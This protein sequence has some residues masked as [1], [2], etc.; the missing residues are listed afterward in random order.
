MV[1]H[2]LYV[3]RFTKVG[4]DFRALPGE[5]FRVNALPDWCAMLEGDAVPGDETLGFGFAA[6]LDWRFDGEDFWDGAVF[7][8]S[9]L[10]WRG[11]LHLGRPSTQNL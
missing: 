9:R 7:F 10:A 3:L 6:A 11:Q 1:T 4:F 8:T 5:G 2:I